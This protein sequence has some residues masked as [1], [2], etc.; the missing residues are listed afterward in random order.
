M[1]VKII[2]TYVPHANVILEQ[3]KNGIQTVGNW[4]VDFF[5]YREQFL[6][7]GI[8]KLQEFGDSLGWESISNLL[9]TVK[10]FDHHQTVAFQELIRDL[11]RI[12]EQNGEIHAF[13]IEPI[14]NMLVALT[15]LVTPIIQ[16]II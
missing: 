8:D 11:F 4:G 5:T 2:P 12:S 9:E 16:S 3:T 10:N 13:F 14:Y 7:A 1:I 6:H 15:Q